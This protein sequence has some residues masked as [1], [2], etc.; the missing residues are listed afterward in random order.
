ME[1][2]DT[3][4]FRSVT[5]SPSRY[6]RFVAEHRDGRALVKAAL[7]RAG[8]T[9]TIVDC[10]MGGLPGS[11]DPSAVAPPYTDMFTVTADDCFRILDELGGETL[12]V[13]HFLGSAVPTAEMTDAIGSLA[14][15]ARARGYRLALE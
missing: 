2:A 14:E 4:G 7:A 10:L 15:K 13:A 5:V 1:A 9:V 3:A 11:P 8:I 12:Q 6:E